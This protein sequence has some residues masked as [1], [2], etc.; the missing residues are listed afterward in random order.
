MFNNYG[1]LVPVPDILNINGRFTNNSV[2]AKAEVQILSNG[3]LGDLTQKE[4]IDI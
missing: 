3:I 2:I 1:D 4:N